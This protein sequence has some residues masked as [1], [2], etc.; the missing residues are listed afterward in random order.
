MGNVVAETARQLTLRVV[1]QGSL[2]L[3]KA[4]IQ[5]RE[6]SGS[7]LMPSGLLRTLSE[8]EVLD[9]VAYLRTTQ[10]VSLPAH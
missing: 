9:L 10:Q 2:S 7:S 5:S 8:S 3:N 1:G 4:D 6:V